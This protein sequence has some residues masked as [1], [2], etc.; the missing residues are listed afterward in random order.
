M[1]H[2]RK[3]ITLLT[4]N[5]FKMIR[6]IEFYLLVP[7]EDNKLKKSLDSLASKVDEIKKQTED[8][9]RI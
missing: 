8:Y 2:R 5:L 4:K 1:N 7:S 9:D 6:E 3:Y